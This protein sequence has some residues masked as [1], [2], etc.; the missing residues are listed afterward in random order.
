MCCAPSTQPYRCGK[1]LFN[2]LA[3]DGREYKACLSKLL[4][5][6]ISSVF[7]WTPACHSIRT[8]CAR[9][10]QP[11]RCVFK[12]VYFYLFLFILFRAPACHSTR[13]C[14]A[15]STLPYRCGLKVEAFEPSRSK[16]SPLEKTRSKLAKS[17]LTG[18]STGV[19]SFDRDLLIGFGL[20]RFTVSGL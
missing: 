10:T 6:A 11:Y 20:T 5:R 1:Q 19:A 2:Y 7:F 17:S 3:G 8:C 13:A 14:C 18:G 15:R 9:S 16:S 4:L 12:L